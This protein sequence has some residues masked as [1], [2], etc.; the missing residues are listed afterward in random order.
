[1]TK[2]TRG[3]RRLNSVSPDANEMVDKTR[4]CWSEEGHGMEIDEISEANPKLIH[5]ESEGE[6]SNSRLVKDQDI[7]SR[8]EVKLKSVEVGVSEVDKGNILSVEN[9]MKPGKDMC[10]SQHHCEQQRCIHT[11][12]THSLTDIINKIFQSKRFESD[13]LERLLLLS[14]KPEIFELDNVPNIP[15]TRRLGWIALRSRSRREGTL[16]VERSILSANFYS[17]HWNSDRYKSFE[18]DTETSSNVSVHNASPLLLFCP[19]RFP[20]PSEGFSGWWS[21]VVYIFYLFDLYS[22]SCTNATCCVWWMW[23]SHSALGVFSERRFSTRWSI[24]P[25]GKFNISA[26][27]YSTCSSSSQLRIVERNYWVLT[28]FINKHKRPCFA[29]KCRNYKLCFCG[30]FMNVDYFWN[31]HSN[32]PSNYLT[33]CL[34]TKTI[35]FVNCTS[36]SIFLA[37]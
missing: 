29:I 26:Y 28:I 15:F 35:N 31:E 32:N 6:G 12:R 23:C 5:T 2:Q 25:T 24:V 37:A 9:E 20:F 8:S 3:P 18:F 27:G 10:S 16:L 14:L 22:A 13:K 7:K 1:M 33:V 36:R 21:V 30:T 19:C 11:Q 34:D 17:I 4:S